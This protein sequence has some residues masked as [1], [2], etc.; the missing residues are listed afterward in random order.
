M[1]ATSAALPECS[2]PSSLKSIHDI[3][4][5]CQVGAG[6]EWSGG[7]VLDKSALY[8]LRL[9]TRV[10]HREHNPPDMYTLHP[11][12]KVRFSLHTTDRRDARMKNR[13][14]SSQ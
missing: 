4:E 14:P 5:V 13:Q 12:A 3:V 2:V 11:T 7:D 10:P 8:S 6:V 1:E 9:L